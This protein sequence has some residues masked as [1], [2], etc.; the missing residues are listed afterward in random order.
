MYLKRKKVYF[1]SQFQKFQSTVLGFIDLRPMVRQSI[2]VVGVCGGGCALH[3][4]QKTERD[5]RG[6]DQV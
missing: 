5:R 1:G 3:G 6:L 4:S 2:M